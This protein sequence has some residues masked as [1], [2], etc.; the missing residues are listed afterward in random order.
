M[1]FDKIKAMNDFKIRPDSLTKKDLKNFI[2]EKSRADV[3]NRF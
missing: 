3:R 1:S 2:S